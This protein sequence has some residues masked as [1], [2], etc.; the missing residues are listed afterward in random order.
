MLFLLSVLSALA[1]DPSNQNHNM[2]VVYHAD[3][4]QLGTEVDFL[5][6]ISEIKGTVS[7]DISD[8]SASFQN[9]QAKSII[10]SAKNIA[11]EQKTT[12]L[13]FD[14]SASMR[15][16]RP[17]MIAAAKQFLGALDSQQQKDHTIDIVL[18]AIETKVFASDLTPAAAIQMLD[19]LPTPTQ[20][21]TALRDLLTDAIEEATK[22]NDPKKGGMRQ[23]ILFS[24]GEEESSFE[25]IDADK[26]VAKAR[27][28]G[29]QV[30]FLFVN[31]SMKPLPP[32]RLDK[33]KRFQ[34][35]ADGTGGVDVIENLYG[36]QGALLQG[37]GKIAS[38]TGK[39]L[40]V[41]MNICE[42][43]QTGDNV[44]KL[45]YGASDYAWVEHHLKNDDALKADCPCVPACDGGLRCSEGK[46]ISAEKTES[47]EE[48]TE[49]SLQ[50]W[51]WLL[52]LPLLL[53]PLL[54]FL[55][56]RKKKKSK[57][58]T[59]ISDEAP[60]PALEEPPPAPSGLGILTKRP[61][62]YNMILSV[63]QGAGEHKSLLKEMTLMHKEAIL[64]RHD[65]GAALQPSHGVQHP[66]LS[67]H[68]LK[69]FLNDDKTVEIQDM[70]AR[71]GVILEDKET[72]KWT[73]MEYYTRTRFDFEKD[74]IILFDGNGDPAQEV[75]LQLSF[76]EE[77]ME[78]EWEN[79]TTMREKKH[80]P[81]VSR[82]QS[83]SGSFQREVIHP[84][85]EQQKKIETPRSK[86]IFEPKK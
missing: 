60:A 8:F 77:E 48:K 19:S 52:L 72:K 25:P 49:N 46:C 76:P 20:Q 62:S 73:E 2:H 21:N 53:L 85:V 83:G 18:G 64:G 24:D 79:R 37:A 65:E 15:K 4:N 28:E 7:T 45:Q 23:V 63:F 1:N 3:A 39:L 50:D 16:S 42:A 36:G 32:A 71:N 74:I 6:D 67:K 29:V 69:I 34:S 26:L 80:T 56:T 68:H 61:I 84:H 31:N 55:L 35:I 78:G 17:L 13:A 41:R 43:K 44:L 30:H 66:E 82:S 27:S 22:N 14:D 75:W 10:S 58:T 51:W 57:E 47:E 9:A 40:R 12:V 81:S 54:L 11:D 86:T 33:I 5:L 59:T 70:G 38:K